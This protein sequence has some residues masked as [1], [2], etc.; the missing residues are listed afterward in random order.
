MRIFIYLMNI[1]TVGRD[2]SMKLKWKQDAVSPVIA[3]I[4]MVAITVVLAAVLYVMVINVGSGG[5]LN[6]APVGGWNS[7]TGD[8]NSSGKLY[9]GNFQPSVA[10][11]DIKLIVEDQGGE[12]FLLWWPSLVN[13]ENYTMACDNS[14]ITAYYYDINPEANSIGSGDYV[15]IFGLESY[16]FYSVRI[17]HFPSDSVIEMAGTKQFQTVP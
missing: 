8:S 3:T 13:S 1:L 14:S 17:Y 15:W 4:L 11:M 12:I 10:P 9:F 7:M 5:A 6:Q 2:I 16:T